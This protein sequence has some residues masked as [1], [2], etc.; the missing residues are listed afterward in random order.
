V[1]HAT[2]SRLLAQKGH[3][4][5]ADAVQAKASQSAKAQAEADAAEA[6]KR[7]EN[8]WRWEVLA[9]AWDSINMSPAYYVPDQVTR[10]LAEHH[11]SN[12]YD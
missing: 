7:F 9:A 4:D 5:H 1:D 2:A 8:A 12:R 10:H 11:G 3:Q 6:K